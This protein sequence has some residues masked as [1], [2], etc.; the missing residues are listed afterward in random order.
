V[1]LKGSLVCE[2]IVR[3]I[4]PIG[5]RK[6]VHEPIDY[7]ALHGSDHHDHDSLDVGGLLC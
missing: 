3:R 4:D 5:G 6:C 2:M 7:S 1:F